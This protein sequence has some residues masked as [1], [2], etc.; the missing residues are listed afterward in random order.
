M[1]RGR[2]NNFSVAQEGTIPLI[3]VVVVPRVVEPVPRKS[4]RV[5]FDAQKTGRTANQAS[6]HLG[7]VNGIGRS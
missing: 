3:D 5:N 4:E 7:T 2:G 6:S 1:R